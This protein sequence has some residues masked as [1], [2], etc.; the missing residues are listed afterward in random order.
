MISGL[1]ASAW[2]DFMVPFWWF[3]KVLTIKLLQLL[4]KREGILPWHLSEHEAIISPPGCYKHTLLTLWGS[5]WLWVKCHHL[6]CECTPSALAVNY[7]NDPS[8]TSWHRSTAAA[9]KWIDVSV[10]RYKQHN[11]SN[12]NQILIVNCGGSTLKIHRIHCIHQMYWEFLPLDDI[13][14]LN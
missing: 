1:H 9:L 6:L 11:R 12:Q 14:K 10:K 4:C 2:N 5:A 7:R 3:H 13:F 8:H